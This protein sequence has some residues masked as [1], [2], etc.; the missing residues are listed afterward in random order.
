MGDSV[1]KNLPTVALI[2]QS[3][4]FA[5]ARLS[6]FSSIVHTSMC[7]TVGNQMDMSAT[8]V[9]ENLLVNGPPQ[10]ISEPVA[11]GIYLE[12]FA[13]KGDGLRMMTLVRKA[14]KRGITVVLYKA[15]RTQAGQAAVATHTA[16]MATDYGNFLRL[17][18]HSG[19]VVCSNLEE[20]HNLVT[21]SSLL[22]PK[23]KELITSEE[24]PETVGICGL[25]N[26]G[27]L[28]CGM[29]DS[30]P[31][32]V[33]GHK[34]KIVPTTYE[35]HTMDAI[36]KVYADYKLTDVVEIGDFLDVTPAVSFLLPLSHAVSSQTV[37]QITPLRSYK[38]LNQP[39]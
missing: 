33:P 27:Y 5:V 14:R 6:G 3:G 11:V 20:F 18:E 17:M 13:A 22:G 37:P 29:A 25:T 35:E 30:L 31:K 2:C 23:L 1:N 24:K 9:L 16:S 19:A 7:V 8:D 39:D 12:G 28:K 36:K 38:K 34:T 26:T 4:G 10:G 15:G 21:L 32:P